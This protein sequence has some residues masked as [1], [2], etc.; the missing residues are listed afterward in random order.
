[1]SERRSMGSVVSADLE[2]GQLELID[3]DQAHEAACLDAEPRARHLHQEDE[4]GSRQHV[5]TD[6][7]DDEHERG[8]CGIAKHGEHGA[9]SVLGH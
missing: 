4:R 7:V 1:M 5:D 3:L 2:L 8:A 6:L 9:A